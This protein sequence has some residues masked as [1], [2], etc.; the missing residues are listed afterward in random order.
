MS[1]KVSVLTPSIRPKGLEIV[2]KALDMQTFRDFEWI[3]GSPKK[4]MGIWVEDTYRDGFWSLNR[5]YN[6]MIEK[7]G[8]RLVVSWQ[9]Y[10][11]AG[12]DALS[13]FW[14][15]FVGNNKSVVT[16]VGHKYSDD[17][18]KEIVWRDPRDNGQLGAFRC[19]PIAVE[20]NYCSIPRKALIDIGGFDEEMDYLGYG[21]D[22]ISIVQRIEACGDYDFLIDQT[23]RSY[24]LQHGRHS[25]WEENNL[26]HGG[27]SERRQ[28]LIENG[29]WPK[30]N[31][32]QL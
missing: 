21:M 24:S 31:Y 20:F 29:S 14:N 13:K 22:G 3:V 7:A 25:G 12:S 15:M 10:T 4:T 23:N 28:E 9:D 8:G 11:W 5:I 16:G 30:L 32:L 1:T 18:W 26:I 27:Y 19:L 6:R 2:K 17:G